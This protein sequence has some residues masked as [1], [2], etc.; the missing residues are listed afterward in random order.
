MSCVLSYVVSG[1]VLT[2]GRQI[3]GDPFLCSYV[4]FWP[5]DSGISSLP[6]FDS[7]DLSPVICRSYNWGEGGILIEN[8]FYGVVV[9]MSNYHPR[10]SGFVY[11]LYS[12]HFSRTIWSGT[13]ST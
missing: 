1:K 2:F 5:I 10:R 9:S 12:I 13:G 6:L 8:R 7:L 3:H 4:V 11:R